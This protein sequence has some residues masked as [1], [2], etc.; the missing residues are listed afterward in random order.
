MPRGGYR[1][2]AG[3]KKEYLEPV[4]KIL[5]GLPESVLFQLDEYAQHNALSRPKAIAKLLGQ[6]SNKQSAPKSNTYKKSKVLEELK[7][8]KKDL[9]NH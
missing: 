2:G 7:A 3:R 9:K 6:L 8:L 4:I 1:K 5:I